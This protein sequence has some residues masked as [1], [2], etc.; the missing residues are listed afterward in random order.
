MD[1]KRAAEV[2]SISSEA[3]CKRIKRGSLVAEKHPDGKVWAW[4]DGELTADR[5]QQEPPQR[6]LWWR[7]FLG[8]E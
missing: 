5:T 1:V 2:L 3:V 4:L 6:H 7:E 8:M